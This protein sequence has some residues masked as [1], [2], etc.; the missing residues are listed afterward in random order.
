[1]ALLVGGGNDIVCIDEDS[2]RTKRAREMRDE[3]YNNNQTPLLEKNFARVTAMAEA[4]QEQFRQT[5][6]GPLLKTATL[7][8]EPSI[9]W[10]ETVSTCRCRPD[11]LNA[12][13][14][15][16]VV[17]H[18][19]TTG[20]ELTP[21][22]LSRHA[23]QLRW[24]IIASHY[25]AGVKSLLGSAPEQWFAIQQTSPP[26][27]CRVAK[28]DN[29]FI[30]MGHIS[31]YRALFVWSR[32]LAMNR[33]PGFPA[34]S[35]KLECPGWHEAQVMESE[36]IAKESQPDPLKNMN[37]TTKRTRRTTVKIIKLEAENIKRLCAVEI[38]PQGNIVEITG[39]NG[40]GKTSVL[41]S[42]WWGLGGT[43]THQKV[44]IRAGQE[45][46]RIKLD[47][48]ELKV[49][50]HF[51]KRKPIKE[52]QPETFTTRITVETNKGARYQSPQHM[53]DK[54]LSS[55]SF[56]PLKF[57]NMESH[58]QHKTLKSLLGLDFS[59]LEEAYTRD[60]GQRAEY[61]RTAKIARAAADL[62]QFPDDTPDEQKHIGKLVEKL[63]EGEAF[64]RGIDAEHLKRRKWREDGE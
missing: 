50:R 61:N 25:E 59:D 43:R 18:Y 48:G 32:C 57:A 7:M 58:E 41:D 60:Y 11:W 64:N 46:A 24:D 33:W 1:M 31:R 10:R 6:I 34:V 51:S 38:T 53:L 52:G 45:Y 35:M 13:Y 23:V 2:F 42:I 40:A 47:L 27:L 17:I 49:T 5:P 54:L 28:L 39:A 19:K 14:E 21:H 12:D 36:R 37:R 30:E 56:D 63:R 29:T 62:I 15:T 3:A 9:F 44:P 8:S 22:N 55:L 4:G 26:H 16:P 20:T